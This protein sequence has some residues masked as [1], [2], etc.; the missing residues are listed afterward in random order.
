MI[1]NYHLN[2][3]DKMPVESEF[4]IMRH[5]ERSVLY[6]AIKQLADNSVIV[7]VGSALGGSACIMAAANPTITVNCIEMF[8]GVRIWDNIKK[9]VHQSYQNYY[10]AR[11]QMPTATH[12]D[13]V[14]SIDNCFLIDPSGKLAFETITKNFSNIKLHTGE[15][16]INFLNWIQ[17][18]DMYLEDATHRNPALHE[19]IKF[20]SN[21]IK[22]GGFIIG[23]D[24]QNLDTISMPDV[25]SEFNKLI[26]DGWDLIS[27]IDS[28]IILQKPRRT[29]LE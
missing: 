21:H 28:L 24:Y 11:G 18:I 15:S 14:N 17:P 2:M 27:K 7:E 26:L 29:I 12:L 3:Q 16:P 9:R 20:W 25:V 8:Q 6:S 23:H 13:I 22:P 4:A 1:L 5:T 10:S 19:N